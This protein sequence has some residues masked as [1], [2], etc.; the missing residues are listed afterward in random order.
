MFG[1]MVVFAFQ[2]WKN[3]NRQFGIA[4]KQLQPQNVMRNFDCEVC[5]F[6]IQNSPKQVSSSD[7]FGG[8]H[9]ILSRASLFSTRGLTA[10]ARNTAYA[11]SSRSQVGVMSVGQ[12]GGGKRR[13]DRLLDYILHDTVTLRLVCAPPTL[14]SA[15]RRENKNCTI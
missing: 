6:A 11:L 2:S 3:N 10:H 4:K 15:H 12:G 9:P 1:P 13:G 14:S 5:F 7:A 8:P